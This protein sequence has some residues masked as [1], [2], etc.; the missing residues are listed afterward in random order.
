MTI[1]EINA[2]HKQ[3]LICCAAIGRDM[4]PGEASSAIPSR[5]F[6]LRPESP[7]WPDSGKSCFGRFLPTARKWGMVS[8]IG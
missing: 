2:D 1:E 7:L 6:R 8:G 3:I 4:Q 5:I